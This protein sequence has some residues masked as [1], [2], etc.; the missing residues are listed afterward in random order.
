MVRS[1]STKVRTTAKTTVR[2][3]MSP[4]VATVKPTASV[5]SVARMMTRKHISCAVVVERKKVIG[6]VSERDIVKSLGKQ[7]NID[8]DEITVGE[9][10]SSPVETLSS[11]TPLERAVQMMKEKGYRRFPITEADGSLAGIVTQSDVLREFTQE[12]THAHDRLEQM[13]THD[14]L[15]RLYNRRYFIGVLTR[16]FLTSKRYGDPISLIM[17]DIDNFKQINDRLGHQFGDTVLVQIAH[18]LATGRRSD[19]V[20]RFGGEEFTILARRIGCDSS[21]Q[22]AD[23]YRKLI[24]DTG[25][26][27]SFGVVCYPNPS[28][29]NM[30]DLIRLADLA[31]YHSKTH[32]KNQVT[33]W[34]PELDDFASMRKT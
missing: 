1:Q 13:A 2:K 21:M 11:C 16:E 30:E 28:V 5:R 19:V 20:G 31:M 24:E 26:T 23:R 25:H 18:I 14:H 8:L 27:A 32:G 6:I 22:V 17:V 33:M 29:S 9:I 10:M 4:Q 34:T 3:V 12:L 15:T 7:A